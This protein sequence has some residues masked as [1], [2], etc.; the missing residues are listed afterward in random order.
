MSKSYRRDKNFDKKRPDKDISSRK[1]RTEVKKA[2][3]F[4]QTTI[5]KDVK[6]DV[7]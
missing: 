2:I 3:W 5:K 6:R 7:D 4:Y 1:E